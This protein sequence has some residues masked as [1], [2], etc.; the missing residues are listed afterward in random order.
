MKVSSKKH[1][2]FSTRVEADMCTIKLKGTL[3]PELLSERERTV[4]IFDAKAGRATYKWRFL[5]RIEIVTDSY[6]LPSTTQEEVGKYVEF[7]K[8]SMGDLI[9]IKVI[10]GHG[11]IRPI[12]NP[13]AFESEVRDAI[14]EFDLL[15]LSSCTQG[16]STVS[17]TATAN[18]AIL[19]DAKLYVPLKEEIN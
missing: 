6:V 3:A 10:G 12:S 11:N 14:S 8:P 17:A 15:T 7:I 5:Q 4:Y 16:T 18:P 19:L 1:F 9:M 2:G 13:S